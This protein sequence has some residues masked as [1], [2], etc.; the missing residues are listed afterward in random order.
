MIQFY[1]KRTL[2]EIV[3]DTFNFLKIYGKNFFKNYLVINGLLLILMM[4]LFVVGL[5]DIIGS[6]MFGEGPEGN[7][8]EEYITQNPE[9][10]V[11]VVVLMFLIF[12]VAMVINYSYPVLYIKRLSETGGPVQLQDILSDIKKNTGRI[13]IYFLG[14]TFIVL[15]FAFLVMAI[16]YILILILIG[17][18][19][20]MIVMPFIMNVINLTL[21]DYLNTKKGFFSSL[22]YGLRSQFSYQHHRDGSPFWKY[23][24]ST[25]VIYII[26]QIVASIFTTIPMIFIFGYKIIFPTYDSIEGEESM[27]GLMVLI[28]YSIALIISFIINNIIY[29][30]TGFIYY[31]SRTD[32]HKK[33]DLSEIESIGKNED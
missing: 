8:I 12:M 5:R 27:F 32:L 10:I 16:S 26:V 30:A 9:L 1:K 20:M 11:A 33:I 19:L 2:G 31:D 6:F 7:Y 4:V 24:G 29:I 25:L 18:F 21:F 14:I 17:L 22:S 23:I 28:L 13:F 15:P 3:S